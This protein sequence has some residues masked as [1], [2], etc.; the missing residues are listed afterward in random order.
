M[1]SSDPDL[2]DDILE[3]FANYLTINAEIRDES[4]HEQLR[5]DLVAHLWAIKGQNAGQPNWLSN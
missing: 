4:V 2:P 5:N 3:D 1:C